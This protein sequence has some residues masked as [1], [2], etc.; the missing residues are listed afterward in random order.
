MTDGLIDPHCTCSS[1]YDPECPYLGHNGPVQ[2]AGSPV[3]TDRVMAED[4]FEN[5]AQWLK[6]QPISTRVFLLDTIAV[7]LFAEGWG[8]VAFEV[9]KAA[10][11]LKTLTRHTP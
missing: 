4:Y 8:G 2:K 3:M 5:F 6:L 7:D 1:G 11:D 9:R 10:E